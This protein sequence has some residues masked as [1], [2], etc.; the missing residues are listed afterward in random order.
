MYILFSGVIPSKEASP[1]KFA[2]LEDDKSYCFFQKGSPGMDFT[3]FIRL[4]GI[5][6]CGLDTI[7][8]TATNT[9]HFKKCV[10][11][12]NS[13]KANFDSLILAYEGNC[14][15]FKDL[16]Y[17]L[18]FNYYDE[19]SLIAT[20]NS[21]F[22]V[23]LTV[24]TETTGSPT[25]EST[26]NSHDIPEFT[27]SDNDISKFSPDATIDNEILPSSTAFDSSNSKNITVSTGIME[28]ITNVI[29]RSTN[30]NRSV[31]FGGLSLYN[32]I[33]LYS[34]LYIIPLLSFF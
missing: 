24:K 25:I 26:S 28:D 30:S 4:V 17:P 31:S 5:I 6:S 16:F 33:V 2:D 10:N 19:T 11:A 23:T 13:V 20:P 8:G 3:V 27:V 12:S 29:D 9:K 32:F 15:E 34:I 1:L 18:D 7:P 22:T 14:T 21:D